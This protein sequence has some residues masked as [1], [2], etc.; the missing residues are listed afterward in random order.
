MNRA[1]GRW[2]IGFLWLAIAIAVG[3]LVFQGKVGWDTGVYW[4]AIK[5]VERNG[6]PYAEGIAVQQIFHN[7]SHDP[8]AAPPMTYVYS[9]L[10]LP[11]LR[12][13]G[14]IPAA[15]LG[16]AYYLALLG[17]F[18]LQLW[19]G[20]SMATP[21]ERRVLP[22]LFPFVAFF[23]GLLNEAVLLSGNIAYILYGLIL[24][25]A[26]PGWRKSRWGWY[27]LAVLFASVCKAPLLT[28]I[29]FPALWDK[30]QRFMAGAVGAIGTVLF[31]CQS[32]LFP[33]LFPEYL[34][35]VNMQF[36]FNSDFGFGPAGLIAG[37]LQRAG[38]PY[39]PV[40][41]ICY[42]VFALAVLV[43][44]WRSRHY[45]Y[46]SREA[47]VTWLPVLL[48]GTVLLN[49]RIKEYDVAALTIPMFLIAYRCVATARECF[50]E[51]QSRVTPHLVTNT[52]RL[53]S[54]TRPMNRLDGKSL[55]VLLTALGW[56]IAINFAT[57]CGIWKPLELGLLLLSFG[58]GSWTFVHRARSSCSSAESGAYGIAESKISL[59]LLSERY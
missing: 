20:W 15:L 7:Q 48:V 28:L 4:S 56:F 36:E 32:R 49:P 18:L 30:R 6:D 59:G 58:A 53:Q 41:D 17:G 39:S 26:V 37:A 21:D 43:V 9:P 55:H 14:H 46:L 29:A 11:L 33:S 24:A 5:S 50:R 27:Y 47:G 1:I 23:P 22:Y 35:A 34:R 3:V 40:A 42:L 54:T 16:V 19:G 25:A 12:I 2:V 31:A 45:S 13:L 38:L 57:A 52:S 8:Q 10:T 44:L 51:S